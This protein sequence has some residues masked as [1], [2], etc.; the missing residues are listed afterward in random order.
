MIK[1]ALKSSI[2]TVEYLGGWPA[3]D[4]Q[5]VLLFIQIAFSF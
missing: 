3:G 5:F 1:R 2:G 4:R